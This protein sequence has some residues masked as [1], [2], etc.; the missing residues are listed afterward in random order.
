MRNFMDVLFDVVDWYRSLVQ[1]Q[2][3][4]APESGLEASA[5]APVE[6]SYP[7]YSSVFDYGPSFTVHAPRYEKE[8][9]DG[10]A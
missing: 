3:T 2:D 1:Q 8:Q 9:L 10:R 5:R 4:G 7:V 6:V